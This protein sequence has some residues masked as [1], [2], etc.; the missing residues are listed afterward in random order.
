MVTKTPRLV[1]T[2][3]PA[4]LQ[5][6]TTLVRRGADGNQDPRLQDWWQR[7][8]LLPHLATQSLI[9]AEFN[10]IL[11]FC[12]L[13][14]LPGNHRHTSSLQEPL[15]VIHFHSVRMMNLIELKCSS[16]QKGVF[17]DRT[18]LLIM[19]MSRDT[20][21][22][23]YWSQLPDKD[24]EESEQHV[25]K[26]VQRLDQNYPV[27]LLDMWDEFIGDVKAD[28]QLQKLDHVLAH[29]FFLSVYL[30]RFSIWDYRVLPR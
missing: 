1:A 16:S 2:A 4:R 15:K 24:D 3:V 23:R 9:L 13:G 17:F 22:G 28:E 7:P 29:A 27:G 26:T 6:T 18:I 30:N 19:K 12:W 21:D 10:E 8:L 25:L 11:I 5:T 20:D 14:T